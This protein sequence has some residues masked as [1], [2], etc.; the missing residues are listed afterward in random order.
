MKYGGSSKQ[1]KMMKLSIVPSGENDSLYT[2]L[3][4]MPDEF[5]ADLENVFV[6]AYLDGV[7]AGK[8]DRKRA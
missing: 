5:Q 7:R 4:S 1:G 6:A 3:Q 8:K 2:L